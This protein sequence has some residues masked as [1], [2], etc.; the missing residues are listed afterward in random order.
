MKE[1]YMYE[2]ME[3]VGKYLIFKSEVKA[4]VTCRGEHL[5]FGYHS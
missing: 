1:M 2:F 5:K 3:I 4:K